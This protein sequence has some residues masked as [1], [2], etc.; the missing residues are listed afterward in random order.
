MMLR[1]TAIA[2]F[3][4]A[5]ASS[6]AGLTGSQ[7]SGPFQDDFDVLSSDWTFENPGGTS[8]YAV[9]GGALQLSVG[10]GNDQWINVNRAPRLL[11][12]QPSASWTI[13]TK[14]VS[15]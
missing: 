2:L 4:L 3:L 8:S 13:E 10:R 9:A 7:A 6:L 11:K 14:V 15:N 5:C 12:S 1:A